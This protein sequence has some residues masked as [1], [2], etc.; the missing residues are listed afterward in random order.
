M[1]AHSPVLAGTTHSGMAPVP[2]LAGSKHPPTPGTSGQ[3]PDFSDVGRKNLLDETHKVLC[4]PSRR[5]S[6]LLALTPSL[7]QEREGFGYH[8]T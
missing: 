6:T 5:V 8:A 3:A 2:Y 4:L 1:T 7:T